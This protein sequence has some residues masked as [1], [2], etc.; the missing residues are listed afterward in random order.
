M[1]YSNYFPTGYQYFAP[2]YGYQPQNGVNNEGFQN[3]QPNIQTQQ[4]TAVN[5]LIWVSGE[6]SAKAY[7]V[8]PNQTVVLW[9]SKNQSVYLKSADATGMP[10]MKILDYTI[11]EKDQTVSGLQKM[12]QP[13]MSNY[14]TK[15]ELRKALE[16]VRHESALRTN[17]D[18][19]AK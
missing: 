1:A 4:S 18:K 7:P 2:Q 13:D 12:Q 16:G 15:E 3:V 14:V 5:G 6:S 8:A 9:D 17:A 19:T 11:R 10:S